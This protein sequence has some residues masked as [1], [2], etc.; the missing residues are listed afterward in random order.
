[1]LQEGGALLA[2]L[3][4]ASPQPP[5]D[6]VDTTAAVSAMRHLLDDSPSVIGG[7]VLPGGGEGAEV[8]SSEFAECR[9][10]EKGAG[11]QGI[12]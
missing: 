9:S 1:M 2:S 7:Q 3:D 11:G 12:R 4:P 5:P 10:C 6:R 8:C